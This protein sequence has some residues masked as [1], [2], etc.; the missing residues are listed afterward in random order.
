MNQLLTELL[1]CG[2]GRQGTMHVEK[3]DECFHGK[4]EAEADALSSW[5]RETMH[6]LWTEDNSSERGDI[7]RYLETVAWHIG[8]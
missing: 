2:K 8:V 3:E 6:S 1:V 5:T 4:L 7:N